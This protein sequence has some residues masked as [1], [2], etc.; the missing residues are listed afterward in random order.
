MN[1]RNAQRKEQP[2]QADSV[3]ED[4]AEVNPGEIV[5]TILPSGVSE[6]IFTDA[7][8][9]NGRQVIAAHPKRQVTPVG[10]KTSLVLEQPQYPVSLGK[11][12]NSTASKRV[13]A[14]LSA[15]VL[16]RTESHTQSGNYQPD[17]G[18]GENFSGMA[19]EPCAGGKLEPFS[20][21]GG[22]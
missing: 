2:S 13:F 10:G 20:S 12:P 8:E 7:I 16:C 15:A 4:S 21:P 5:T 6:K 22:V 14:L 9:E 17:C 19:G 3:E 11:Q 1:G 18:R